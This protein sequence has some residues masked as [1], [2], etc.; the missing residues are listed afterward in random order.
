[1]T[2][3]LAHYR[4]EFP[5]TQQYA[6]LS[7]AAVSSLSRRVGNA[8]RPHIE[9]VEQ[10][11]FWNYMPDVLAV[12]ERLRERIAR[13]INAR[14]SSEIVLTQNTAMSI[15]TVAA[16]LPFQPGDNV[17]VL[18]G[19]YPANV[20]PWLNQAH[21]GVL[22]KFVPAHQGGL[23]IN[24]LEQRIDK[25]TRVIALSTVMFSTGF[26]NDIEAVGKLCHERGIYFVVDAIQSLGAF[27]IDVQS[28]HIDFLAAGSQKWLMSLPGCGLLYCRQ[29][30][31]DELVPGA[32]VGTMSVLDPL[33]Y[34]DYNFTLQPDASR[35]NLGTPN[36][37]G[38]VALDAAIELLQE[39]G[40]E[41]ISQQIATLVDALLSDLSERGYVVSGS[42]AP[43]HRSGI[44]VA[45]VPNAMNLCQ[46][47]SKEHVIVT[48]RGAGVRV[49]PHFYNTV[50]EVL[51][52]GELLDAFAK[53]NY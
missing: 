12:Q 51:R 4:D 16:S 6:F 52:V 38:I 11:H 9:R 8:V 34:L 20:Y 42:T 50:E 27:P 32:Y 7:H 28:S 10:D 2:T 17:L 25:R 31:I 47:M 23:D 33:N 36:V 48:P 5:V 3:D 35:F 18:E 49:A 1:M 13:L 15:S 39:V 53:E 14:S 30:R 21:R 45:K 40:I 44:V 41:R 29:E 19:D 46:R 22:T 37:T 26:R 24:L 43:E